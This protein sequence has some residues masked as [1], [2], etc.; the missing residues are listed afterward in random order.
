VRDIKSRE[1][2]VDDEFPKFR[3]QTISQ[4]PIKRT[5][6]FVKQKKSRRWRKRSSEGDALSLSPR[7]RG[8]VTRS[9]T[10]QTN[11]FEDFGHS[12]GTIGI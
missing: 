1:A 12:D 9:E 5:H 11:K 6:R 2:K 7:Q 8:D 4:D 10:S 3:H